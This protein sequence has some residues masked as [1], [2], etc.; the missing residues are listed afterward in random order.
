MGGQ[1]WPP[2]LRKKFRFAA[3]RPRLDQFVS[4][5]AR[6][7]PEKFFPEALYRSAAEQFA[8]AQRCLAP[9]PGTSGCR[10]SRLTTTVAAVAGGI[11]TQ[12]HAYAK[13]NLPENLFL[14]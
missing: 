12:V 6:P 7:P 5:V 8:F 11:F 3:W 9:R 4:V 1:G 14:S 2:G 10:A 13:F